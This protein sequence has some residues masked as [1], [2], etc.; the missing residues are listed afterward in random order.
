MNN[1]PGPGKYD[2]L[3]KMSGPKISMGVK[4]NNGF[5]DQ[6]VP[7][8]GNYELTDKAINKCPSAFTMGAKYSSGKD[9]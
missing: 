2:Y 1:I 4:P 8:P 7:G 6:N 9:E 5:K 3:Y